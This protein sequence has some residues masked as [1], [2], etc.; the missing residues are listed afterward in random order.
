MAVIEFD[1]ILHMHAAGEK[2]GGSVQL[3]HAGVP[4]EH[5]REGGA[6]ANPH[7]RGGGNRHLRG[8]TVGMRKYPPN[9]QP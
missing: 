6:R 5:H 7:A 9:D 4:A 1:N 8:R 3:L 2:Q